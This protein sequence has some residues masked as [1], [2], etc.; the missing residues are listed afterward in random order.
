MLIAN[1][2]CLDKTLWAD[3]FD[4]AIVG[5]MEIEE[6]CVLVYSSSKCIEVIAE[7]DGISID[8]AIDHYEY[9]VRGS[10]VGTFT[11]KF[12]ID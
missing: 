3:G 2:D 10:Y 7:Q 8:D 12:I 5:L 9:N 1:Y 11:P 6:G 4:D